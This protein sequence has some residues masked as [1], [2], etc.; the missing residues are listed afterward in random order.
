MIRFRAFSVAG[1]FMFKFDALNTLIQ[2]TKISADQYQRRLD[3]SRLITEKKRLLS[4]WH[5]QHSH[6]EL[7]SSFCWTKIGL[8]N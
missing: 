5:A 2:K 1:A 7:F 8:A 3:I 4:G 6:T